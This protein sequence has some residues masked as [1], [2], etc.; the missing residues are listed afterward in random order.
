VSRLAHDALKRLDTLEG[1][2]PRNPGGPTETLLTQEEIKDIE[3]RLQQASDSDPE[4]DEEIRVL[5][6]QLT[7]F[8]DERAQRLVINR[9]R[10]QEGKA[11][12]EALVQAI[13]L[14]NG[15][16]QEHAR[17]SLIERF[18]K[19]TP[20]MLKSKLKS[21]DEETQLAAAKAAGT[22]SA[23]LT[24]SLIE[25]LDKSERVSQ[26]ARAS[27][28]SLTGQDFGPQPSASTAERFAA[29]QRWQRWANSL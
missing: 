1:K 4:S 25:M 16:A 21:G 9:L 29:K 7:D 6:E 5:L 11:Y 8:P 3:Q 23:E 14:T 22:K 18:Q 15:G 13:R 2:A 28:K 19:L 17:Q 26:A 12:S 24:L 10:D 20:G 27:L